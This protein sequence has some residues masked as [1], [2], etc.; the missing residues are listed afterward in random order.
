M[1]DQGGIFA[2]LESWLHQAAAAFEA[3]A[4][5]KLLVEIA[6]ELRRRTQ[7]RMA[8]QT[9]PDGTDWEPRKRNHQ[10]K[11]R[12]KVKLMAGL[13]QARRLLAKG[14]SDQAEIGWEGRLGRI[15]RIHH[16]GLTDM[17]GKKGPRYKYPARPLI[18]ITPDDLDYIRSAIMDRVSES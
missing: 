15:A 16:L 11:V 3:P 14:S 18:D 8:A 13:R 1:D 7:K 5:R 2:E 12:K 17:V 6:R 10:G 9:A 4:R